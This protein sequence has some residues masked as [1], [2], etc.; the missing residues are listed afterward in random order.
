[1]E[2]VGTEMTIKGPLGSRRYDIVVRDS[3]GRYHGIEVKTGGASKTAYQ[4]FTDRF[5][6]LFGGAGTGGLKGV[7]IESTSTVF[8]P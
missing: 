8:L 6:N 2:V 4:D 7:T 5:V 1:M 3:A